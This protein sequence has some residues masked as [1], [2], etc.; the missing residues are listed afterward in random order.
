MNAVEI[1]EKCMSSEIITSFN[2]SEICISYGSMKKHRNG[3]AN[4]AVYQSLNFGVPLP[5][6]FSPDMFTIAASDNFDHSDK[7]IIWKVKYT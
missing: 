3:L 5:S 1:Y 4:L 6:H 7:N 2:K